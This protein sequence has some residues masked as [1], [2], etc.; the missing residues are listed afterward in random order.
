MAFGIVCLLQEE[1][2]EKAFSRRGKLMA[3]EG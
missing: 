1:V 2:L 3:K